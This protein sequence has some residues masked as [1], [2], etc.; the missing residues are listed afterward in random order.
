MGEN[1]KINKIKAM[2]YFNSLESVIRP[3]YDPINK[4][5]SILASDEKVFKALTDYNNME[6]FEN[7][8]IA[9]RTAKESNANQE[10]EDDEEIIDFGDMDEEDEEFGFDGMGEEEEEEEEDDE[11]SVEFED[12]EALGEE[13][14][15]FGN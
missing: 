13:G 5:K 4:I 6:G 3:P 1:G 12:M 11:E 14:E 8:D 9:I 2:V 10:S 7:A 15:S